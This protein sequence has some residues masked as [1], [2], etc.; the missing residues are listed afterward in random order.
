MISVQHI[1]DTELYC[2]STCS[3]GRISDRRMIQCSTCMKNFHAECSD[4]EAETVIWNCNKCRN[5]SDSIDSL[6][7]QISEVHEILSTMV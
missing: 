2:Y 5:V 3:F 6:K 4:A 7:Q 1:Y